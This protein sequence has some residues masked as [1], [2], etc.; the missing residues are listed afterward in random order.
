MSNIDTVVQYSQFFSPF[1]IELIYK[2]AC[3]NNFIQ[4]NFRTGILDII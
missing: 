3:L 2:F 4:S 1:T